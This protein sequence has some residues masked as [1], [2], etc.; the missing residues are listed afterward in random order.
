MGREEIEAEYQRRARLYP[1]AA[2]GWSFMYTPAAAVPSAKAF[3]IG[4]NPGG[5]TA[6]DANEWDYDGPGKVNAYV[7]EAW[8]YRGTKRRAG[9]HPLQRQVAAL[10]EALALEPSEVFAA[11]LVPF[12]S[13]AWAS[14]PDAA[15]ALEFMRPYWR[16]LIGSSQ[17]RIFCSLGKVAGTEVARMIDARYCS[18]HCI[19]HGRQAI[20][21]YR[22]SDRRVVLSMPHLSRFQL[23][24]LEQDNAGLIRQILDA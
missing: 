10:F 16:A 12:R 22:D 20:D 14:L 7:D 8:T 1:D 3:L 24:S 21:V 17:A 4:L 6:G 13:P 23:F 15:G 18:C 9:T 11:N 19:G 5:D 2:W